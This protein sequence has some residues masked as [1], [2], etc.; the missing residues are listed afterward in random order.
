MEVNEALINKLAHLS[1]LRFSAEEKLQVGQDLERM[2]Q[3]VEKL[4]ELDLD[5]VEPLVFMT[6]EVNVLRADEIKGSVS[7]DEALSNAPA[8]TA[9]FFTVPKVIQK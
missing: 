5:Q 9:A 6:E 8:H 7:R 2:I 1:R 4:N 3:F